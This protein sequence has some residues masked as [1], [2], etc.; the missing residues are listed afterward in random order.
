M[1]V[2]IAILVLLLSDSSHACDAN[3]FAKQAKDAANFYAVTLIKGELKNLKHGFKEKTPKDV[4]F[5][6][7][8]L[9]VSFDSLSENPDSKT[10]ELIHMANFKKFR[11]VNDN[12]EEI[13]NS[14]I[15][16]K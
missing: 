14:A 4:H 12:C 5:K 15:Q 10:M 9:F 16:L 13:Y 1:R 11:A 2:M 6:E 3:F 7:Y 8:D